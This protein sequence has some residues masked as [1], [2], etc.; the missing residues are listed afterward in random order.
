MKR[1][2]LFGL[3]MLV[4][5]SM[6]NAAPVLDQ[7]VIGPGGGQASNGRLVM[8]MTIGEPIIGT[9]NNGATTLDYGYWW[10]IMTVNVGVGDRSLP[11][12]YALR[13]TGPNP[14]TTRTTVSYAIPQGQS[15]PVFIGIY[16]INGRLVKT[17][18]SE[19]KSAG[20][21]TAV[22]DGRSDN[23]TPSGAGVYFTKFQAGPYTAT[24]KVVML[25]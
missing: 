12:Q 19:S 7:V 15:V 11:V 25:K 3:F 23:G 4:M 16:D 8:R 20:L 1:T 22:W 2:M 9:G 5:V 17:L 10:S 21:Y 13:Q 18:V 14:F 24:R 6:A